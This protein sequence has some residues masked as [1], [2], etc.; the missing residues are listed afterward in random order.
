MTTQSN[1]ARAAMA[2][3]FDTGSPSDLM[4]AVGQRVSHTLDLAAQE[5]QLA[6]VSGLTMI[7]L[8]ILAAASVVVGWGLVVAAAIWAL[9]GAGVSIPIAT[10]A[11][12]ITHVAA[13]IACWHLVVKLSHN[14]TLPALRAALS[15]EPDV[16]D[17]NRDDRPG[18]DRTSN[19]SA[20]EAQAS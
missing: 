16:S 6:A 15:K 3:D 2:P 17:D 8:I 10:G 18:A 20:R 12:A 1:A 9:A 11:F 19:A 14:L 5:A 4:H 7:L 13:A